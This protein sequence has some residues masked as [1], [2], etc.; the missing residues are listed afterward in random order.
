VGDT[1]RDA[2][3]AAPNRQRTVLYGHAHESGEAEILPN[4]RVLTVEAV[5]GK[6]CVQ[7]VLEVESGAA[8]GTPASA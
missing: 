5:Y 7:R 1:L 3:A 4:L 6:P 2:M 8:R